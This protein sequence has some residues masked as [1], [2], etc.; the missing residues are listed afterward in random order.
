[1]AGFSNETMYANNVNFSGAKSPAVTLDG[2]LMIGAT[3]APNIRIGTLSS[4]DSSVTITNGPGTISLVVAGGSTVG[5][6]ISGNSGGALVPSS[7]NWNIV[8]S[9]SITTSG[10][11]STLTVQLTNLNNHAVLVGAGTATI[12]NVGPTAT[13]GQILQSAGAAADPAFSTATYPSTTTISQILYSSATNVVSG[14]ATANRAVLSTGTTGVPVLTPLAVDGQLLIGST[15][16]APAAAVLTSSGGTVT[17]TNASNSINLEV[18][19]GN[20]P[21]TNVTSTSATMVKQ[22]GYQANN[23]G[24]V[25]LTMPSVVSSTFGDTI[26]VGGFGSG[27]WI[28][29]CVATQ[30]IHFGDTATSAAG[31]LASTNRYD[32]LEIVCSSTTTE[33]FVRNSI[34]NLTIL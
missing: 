8:G 33:W 27:G 24:L 30:L 10:A 19:P 14:L 17:I 3:A 18:V 25:T 15:S 20:F 5:K 9:G 16:G 11:A 7:G 34:G 23:A 26:K 12:T 21:W 31:S 13:P 4:S 2:Q 1:M 22:N 6:T 32:Q 29:Q 28:V